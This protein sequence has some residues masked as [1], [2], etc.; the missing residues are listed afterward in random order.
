LPLLAGH[1][2]AGYV[3]EVGE[4]VKSVK[5][6][7]A[8][9]VSLLLSCGKC[10]YCTSGLPHLCDEVRGPADT[11]S[12]SRNKRGQRIPQM[13][14]VGC[15]AEY[16]IVGESQLVKIPE[17]MPLDRASLLACGVITGFGR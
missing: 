8:V 6:G 12:H 11:Q 5:P 10:L 17:D 13:A 1:E 3:E 4:K 2:S 14:R 9:I 7:D 15:F 16:T